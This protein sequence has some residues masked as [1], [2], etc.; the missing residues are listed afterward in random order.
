LERIEGTIEARNDQA[1]NNDARDFAGAPM[2]S[3]QN[4]PVRHF[5]AILTL[6][7]TISASEADT[8]A[9][10]RHE[11]GIIRGSKNEKKIALQ[12]TGDQFAEGAGTILDE[13]ARHKARASFHLTGDFLR[14]P[15]L[16]HL[17]ERMIRDGHYLGPHSDKHLLYC[18]WEGPKVTLV[19]REE[20]TTDLEANIAEIQ[21][22]GVP[23]S[24]IK[25]WNPPYQWYNKEIVEWSDALGLTL[26]NYSPGTRSNAD[27]TEDDAKNFV[28]S[29]AILESILQKEKEDPNGL[30]GFLLL[31]HIGAGPKRTDKMHERFGELLEHLTAKGY[32]F[33]R[34][35]ELLKE[36]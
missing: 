15:A 17:V 16:R 31:L 30:N 6:A 14:N 36:K 1:L 7:M 34:V 2:S 24:A 11:G 35:D 19:T 10:E 9:F 5:A 33:V 18:P 3:R 22:F 28:S 13:L 32:E 25:F 8:N 4:R 20:F 21:K 12:F 26:V 27:Y 23:R 29:Q